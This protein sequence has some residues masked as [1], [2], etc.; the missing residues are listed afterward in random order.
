VAATLTWAFPIEQHGVEPLANQYVVATVC[1]QT[2]AYFA[3]L[4]PGEARHGI[5]IVHAE[6]LLFPSLED[7]RQLA[8]QDDQCW[9]E[10]V[11]DET[12]F[13]A[14]PDTW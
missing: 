11:I 8:D 4:D 1:D 10:V 3:P 14:R 5:S 2:W 9:V 13:W 6:A 7:A 12:E